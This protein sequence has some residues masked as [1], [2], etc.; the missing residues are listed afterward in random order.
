M[1]SYVCSGPLK[2][3]F[4]NNVLGQQLQNFR[5]TYIQRTQDRRSKNI[6]GTWLAAYSLIG[7][8]ITLDASLSRC[9]DAWMGRG[10]GMVW[11]W[12]GTPGQ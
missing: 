5:Q 7:D 1:P 9:K 2:L 3:H 6:F 11:G 12:L 10:G 8:Y 4:C